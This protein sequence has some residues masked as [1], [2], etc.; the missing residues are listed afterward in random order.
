MRSLCVTNLIQL[1]WRLSIPN[2]IEIGSVVFKIKAVDHLTYHSSLILMTGRSCS[3]HHRSCKNMRHIPSPLSSS[4]ALHHSWSSVRFLLYSKVIKVNCNVVVTSDM[5]IWYVVTILEFSRSTDRSIDRS[6][7]T[8]LLPFYCLVDVFMK[9][10]G[11]NCF[12]F[13]RGTVAWPSVQGK[14]DLKYEL[15]T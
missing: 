2:F 11:W 14:G 3:V 12:V 6:F 10:T 4:C 13:V 5:N 8:V 9:I 7:L 1:M 15:P